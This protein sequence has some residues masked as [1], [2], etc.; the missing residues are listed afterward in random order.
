MMPIHY[1]NPI[2]VTDGADQVV[3][4]DL[5]ALRCPLDD[6]AVRSYFRLI[7]IRQLIC[8]KQG[9]CHRTL[10]NELTTGFATKGRDITLRSMSDADRVFWQLDDQ[11]A[12]GESQIVI[13]VQQDVAH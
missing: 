3:S 10:S 13:I 11:T 12:H 5:L 4:Q 8:R 1:D 2:P 9:R 6:Q 7:I